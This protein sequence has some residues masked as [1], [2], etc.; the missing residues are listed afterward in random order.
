MNLSHD[1]T[2]STTNIVLQ[3]LE[4]MTRLRNHGLMQDAKSFTVNGK[5]IRGYQVD[6]DEIGKFFAVEVDE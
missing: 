5:T 3:N 1:G 4:R 6:E 2:I